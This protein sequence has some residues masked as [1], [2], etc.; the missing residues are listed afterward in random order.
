MKKH[1]KQSHAFP[2]AGRGEIDPP[3]STEPLDES[4]APRESGSQLAAHHPDIQR[5]I[6]D[7]IVRVSGGD[8]SDTDRKLVR[9]LV[10]AALKLIPDGRDTGELKLITTSTKELRYAFRVFGEYPEPRKVS[11][12]GSARTPPGH[13]DYD[14]AVE[15][16]REVA[17][18]GWMVITGAGGGIMQAGHEGPGRDNS[19][20]VA[21]RLPFEQETNE[22]I[23]N[24]EKLVNF[25]YFFTRKVTFLSQSD[26]IVCFPGGFGTLDEAF[27]AL[28][29]IQTG[30]AGLVPVVLLEGAG[31]AANPADETFWGGF[32]S[33]LREQ[34]LARGMIHAEDLDLFYRAESSADAVSHITRFYST[35]HSFRYV[36]DDLILRLRRPLPS[37][38]ADALTDEFPSLLASGRIRETEPF[39]QEHHEMDLP[40]IT[41]TH[42][43][44]D[45]GVLRKMI[46]RINELGEQAH[47]DGGYVR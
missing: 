46:D 32:D 5:S 7:L 33:Y 43:R 31:D 47:G 11:I 22:V 28:T 30:K 18:S 14:L 4:A 29:L 19:F 35:Y 39:P 12:F 3:E 8:G 15:F 16:G 17:E 24:D 37:G 1:N 10:T 38:A 27:E 42:T 23:R 20:G 34:L 40:R 44:R 41:F 6:D 25:R 2:V 9:D 21:I 26:A 36:R 45:F 13:P